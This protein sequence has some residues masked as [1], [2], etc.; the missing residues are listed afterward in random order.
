MLLSFMRCSA[1]YRMMLP[2]STHAS[3]SSWQ[4]SA[5][6]EDATS[7]SHAGGGR[8]AAA[9]LPPHWWVGQREARPA[10]MPRGNSTLRCARKTRYR[11]TAA[12]AARPARFSS[13]KRRS[14][15]G[16]YAFITSRI[17]AFAAFRRPRL[18]AAAA[19]RRRLAGVE[20]QCRSLWSARNCARWAQQGGQR[21]PVTPHPHPPH[22]LHPHPAATPKLVYLTSFSAWNHSGTS[23]RAAREPWRQTLSGPRAG[24]FERPEQRRVAMRANFRAGGPAEG[25]GAPATTA[26]ATAAASAAHAGAAAVAGAAAE[27]ASNQPEDMAGI[28][29]SLEAGKPACREWPRTGRHGGQGCRRAAK[30]AEHLHLRMQGPCRSP[31]MCCRGCLAAT[32]ALRTQAAAFSTRCRRRTRSRGPSCSRPSAGTL[33]NRCRAPRG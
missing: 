22:G 12:E 17:A 28:L 7:R 16:L 2:W 5:H 33:N 11:R 27:P 6:C 18:R 9:G 32:A 8:A 19:C 20:R 4:L 30:P 10:D 3:V 13:I 23:P 14:C 29:E 26:P 24:A 25:S 1:P 15:A 21:P 31:M